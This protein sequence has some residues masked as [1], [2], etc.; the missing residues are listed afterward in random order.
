[1]LDDP[2]RARD[3]G[4]AGRARAEANFSWTTIAEQTLAIYAAVTALT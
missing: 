1:M 4:S 3:M 2:G